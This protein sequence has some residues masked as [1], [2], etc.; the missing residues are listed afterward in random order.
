MCLFALFPVEIT[1]VLTLIWVV[2]IVRLYRATREK[3]FK[4]IASALAIYAAFLAGIHYLML[5]ASALAA[6][7]GL[8]GDT[9]ALAPFGYCAKG[10]PFAL[11]GLPLP[12]WAVVAF[13]AVLA[14]PVGCISGVYFWSGFSRLLADG[15]WAAGEAY[16]LC[17]NPDCKKV[18]RPNEAVCPHCGQRYVVES[19]F[20]AERATPSQNGPPSG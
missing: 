9:A 19:L 6:Y 8:L 10:L 12:M 1:V 2:L 15:H 11:T 3:G 5:I 4:L 16:A 18:V 13:E 20:I 17:P 14:L 7:M